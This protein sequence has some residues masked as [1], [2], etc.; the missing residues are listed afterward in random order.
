MDQHHHNFLLPYKCKHCCCSFT[1]FDRWRRHKRLHLRCLKWNK[2]I[3]TSQP[4]SENVTHVRRTAQQ[5]KHG[6]AQ[7]HPVE[8]QDC[9]TGFQDHE[10]EP[11]DGQAGFQDHQGEFQDHQTWIHNHEVEPRDAHSRMITGSVIYLCTYCEV[12]FTSED[13]T[14]HEDNC[15]KVFRAKSNFQPKTKLPRYNIQCKICP[16]QFA[17]LP[18]YQKHLST[19]SNGR[20]GSTSVPQPT[21]KVRGY[22]DERKSCISNETIRYSVGFVVES[23]VTAH[24]VLAGQKVSDAPAQKLKTIKRSKPII[25]KHNKRTRL[26]ESEGRCCAILPKDQKVVCT[27]PSGGETSE[28]SEPQSCPDDS[29]ASQKSGNSQRPNEDGYSESPDYQHSGNHGD[30]SVLIVQ[31]V[32]KDKT[33]STPRSKKATR[34]N[35]MGYMCKYC[36][37]IFRTIPMLLKHTTECTENKLTPPTKK[38]GS[39][40]SSNVVTS[41]TQAGG[42]IVGRNQDGKTVMKHDSRGKGHTI[43]VDVRDVYPS[44]IVPRTMHMRDD[45]DKEVAE[46]KDTELSREEFSEDHSDENSVG[47]RKPAKPAVV[48]VRCKLY[49]RWKQIPPQNVQNSLKSNAGT[50]ES[51]VQSSV[52][53]NAASAVTSAPT[54]TDKFHVRHPLAGASLTPELACVEDNGGG[55]L[56]NEQVAWEEIS[57]DDDDDAP[58]NQDTAGEKTTCRDTESPGEEETLADLFTEDFEQVVSAVDTSSCDEV[59]LHCHP[60]DD[61]AFSVTVLEAGVKDHCSVTTHR[62]EVKGQRDQL[63]PFRCSICWRCFRSFDRMKRHQRLHMKRYC[64]TNLRMKKQQELVVDDKLS[65]HCGR[66]SSRSKSKWVRNINW[67][68]EIC[69]KKFSRVQDWQEHARIYHLRLRSGRKSKTVIHRCLCCGIDLS[70]MIR[71]NKHVVKHMK[72]QVTYRFVYRPGKQSKQKRKTDGKNLKRKGRKRKRKTDGANLERESTDWCVPQL[73]Q[74][75]YCMKMFK[76]VSVASKHIADEHDLVFLPRDGQLQGR[77]QCRLCMKSF[78]TAVKLDRHKLTHPEYSTSMDYINVYDLNPNEMPWDMKRP[79]QCQLCSSTFKNS[80]DAHVHV[81]VTHESNFELYLEGRLT[82]LQCRLC[83]KAP[84]WYPSLQ[85][86]LE[87]KNTHLKNLLS[88]DVLEF[89]ADRIRS[90]GATMNDNT[91]S[92]T[93]YGK[94]ANTATCDQSKHFRGHNLCYLCGMEFTDTSALLS[95]EKSHEHEIQDK[96]IPTRESVEPQDSS[97]GQ[98]E[99]IRAELASFKPINGLFQCVHCTTNPKTFD[100]TSEASEHV[101][102]TH[103][104]VVL[105]Q[106]Y[107]KTKDRYRCRYCDTVFEDM[108]DLMIHKYTHSKYKTSMDYI[109]LTTGKYETLRL[110]AARLNAVLNYVSTKYECRHCNKRFTKDS[111]I[112]NHILEYHDSLILSNNNGL[113]TRVY[114]CRFCDHYFATRDGLVKHKETHKGY[115]PYMEYMEVGGSSLVSKAMAEQ[116]QNTRCRGIINEKEDHS[117]AETAT[118]APE[119]ETDTIQD[120]T[121]PSAAE[122]V[123]KNLSPTLAVIPA[124]LDI[125]A[126]VPKSNSSFTPINIPVKYP[127]ISFLPTFAAKVHKNNLPCTL[128]NGTVSQAEIDSPC[129]SSNLPSTITNVAASQNQENKSSCTPNTSI[130]SNCVKNPLEVDPTKDS[131]DP[132]VDPNSINSFLSDQVKS[133]FA[134]LHQ[135]DADI[136]ATKWSTKRPYKCRQCGNTYTLANKAALHVVKRHEFT[137]LAGGKYVYKCRHCGKIYLK[138]SHMLAHKRSNPVTCSSSFDY[139]WYCKVKKQATSSPAKKQVKKKRTRQYTCRKPNLQISTNPDPK[140][141]VLIHIACSNHSQDVQ[142][143]GCKDCTVCRVCQKEFSGKSALVCHMMVEH[144][145]IQF[146]VPDAK[147]NKTKRMSP[148]KNPSQEPLPIKP[149]PI[150]QTI[151]VKPKLVDPTAEVSI[152]QCYRCMFCKEEFNTKAQLDVHEIR[153]KQCWEQKEGLTSNKDGTTSTPM[154]IV[155]RR[156]I[157]EKPQDAVPP[158]EPQICSYCLKRF[159]TK[160]LLDVHQTASMRCWRKRKQC[161]LGMKAKDNSSTGGEVGNIKDSSG[162]KSSRPKSGDKKHS[163]SKSSKKSSKSKLHGKRHSRSKSCAKSPS[164]KSC[165]KSSRSSGVKHSDTESSSKSSRSKPYSSLYSGSKSS[166]EKFSHHYSKKTKEHKQLTATEGKVGTSSASNEIID[167]T[168]DCTVIDIRGA[169]LNRTGM[170]AIT[171]AQLVPN[172]AKS[173]SKCHKD[174][175]K[176]NY[177]RV[178]DKCV[179]S[180]VLKDSVS[181]FKKRL[182]K[183]QKSKVNKRFKSARESKDHSHMDSKKSGINKGRAQ[184]HTCRCCRRKFVEL[185]ALMKHQVKHLSVQL[186]RLQPDQIPE[187]RGEEGFKIGER[188]AADD[189]SEVESNLESNKPEETVVFTIELEKCCDEDKDNVNNSSYDPSPSI[190]SKKSNRVIV[191]KEASGKAQKTCSMDTSSVKSPSLQSKKLEEA[192]VPNLGANTK[193]ASGSCQKNITSKTPGNYQKINR[194]ITS[195]VKSQ[196]LQSKK[197]KVVSLPKPEADPKEVSGSPQI[198]NSKILCRAKSPS[199]QLK[200]PDMLLSKSKHNVKAQ[201]LQSKKS[202][203]AVFPKAKPGVRIF[204]GSVQKTFGARVSEPRDAQSSNLESELVSPRPSTV[205]ESLMQPEVAASSLPFATTSDNTSARELFFC[206][207]CKLAFH[208]KQEMDL[209]EV[210]HFTNEGQIRLKRHTTDTVFK[211][212][213]RSKKSSAPIG[214]LTDVADVGGSVMK[215]DESAMSATGESS[216]FSG[217]IF[218]SDL[219]GE[220]STFNRESGGESATLSMELKSI[221]YRS[222]QE[223]VYPDFCFGKS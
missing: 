42:V 123:E 147:R 212:G 217:K 82:K 191:P 161:E 112:S 35:S 39:Q 33:F 110:E 30:Q 11:H 83:S 115:M 47:S 162:K 199:T 158:E 155:K 116:N 107:P 26:E 97:P 193:K 177:R 220:S 38:D 192:I 163:R 120:S 6:K 92:S 181:L 52:K 111:D 15:R 183:L 213:Q 206:R 207:V 157:L 130:E 210:V 176:A 72:R 88:G 197:P 22:V 140:D 56:Q 219:I 121:I 106:S 208:E 102:Y 175:V 137:P 64:L 195:N 44:K 80:T 203:V 127:G 67:I 4:I 132:S 27:Q 142:G 84:R 201:S 8:L 196:N 133:M 96:N 153:S 146:H 1:S 54:L 23:D 58:L 178:N 65:P 167:L 131:E 124:K 95:H 150:S 57:D 179:R 76:N 128:D 62:K 17:R 118:T 55:T 185:F 3:R 18:S 99:A 134:Y 71:F 28:E 189:V 188:S 94:Y 211:E 205:E 63:K 14:A 194:N 2:G 19:H 198:M 21:K 34:T 101:A 49:G 138:T 100:S 61:G 222:L 141:P 144:S 48:L 174:P 165:G 77:F 159:D 218:N 149:K 36:K 85:A 129:M 180:G 169:S 136:Y 166:H 171:H 104:R 117:A 151:A 43:A 32:A 13:I 109:Q 105:F 182:K 98:E 113:S 90:S 89:K 29:N 114:Q 87:H 86:L 214:T 216:I 79:Y 135:D 78:S 202:K 5:R 139:D 20:A 74:C 143:P 152:E 156:K 125:P 24:N 66:S 184:S 50:G 160:F 173:S 37:G 45:E 91:G 148:K 60:D 223:R 168:E 93:S 215:G 9:Q 200:K 41:P 70:T 69:G 186:T 164:L 154:L 209:H 12:E 7:I 53:C 46:E 126:K 40:D 170:N 10:V 122:V 187:E 51:D 119:D 16:R 81:I 145:N 103:D 31:S 73:I 25:L 221:I 108:Q 204:P 59:S 172:M 68:C 75:M 190:D